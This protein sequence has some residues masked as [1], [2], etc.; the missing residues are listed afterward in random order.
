MKIKFFLVFPCHLLLWAIHT[1][2]SKSINSSSRPSCVATLKPMEVAAMETCAN[3]L[4]APKTPS[5]GPRATSTRQ[6]NALIFFPRAFATTAKRANSATVQKNTSSKSFG[7]T[8]RPISR[9]P[10]ASK[11]FLLSQFINKKFNY[12]LLFA[13][14]S[15]ISRSFFIFF[16]YY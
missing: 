11:L 1:R 9:L 14:T 12:Y 13:N 5:T 16:I 8:T 6:K 2:A 3:S 7:S 10:A 15:G 4:M